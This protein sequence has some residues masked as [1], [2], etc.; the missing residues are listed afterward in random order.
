[1]AD[2]TASVS[3]TSRRWRA[4]RSTRREAL[5][6]LE[7]DATFEPIQGFMTTVDTLAS[8]RRLSR[9]AFMGET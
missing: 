1:M 7:G 2:A 8:E 4:A 5:C 3:R 9:F 6:A